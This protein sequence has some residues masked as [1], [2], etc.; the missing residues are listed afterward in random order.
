[1]PF[2]WRR[3]FAKRKLPVFFVRSSS[4]HYALHYHG[5]HLP[6]RLSRVCL[7]HQRDELGLRRLK[8]DIRYSDGDVESVLRTHD[9]VDAHLRKLGVGYLE[10]QHDDVSQAIQHQARDGIHQI[11]T[12]RMSARP[13]QGVVD[14]HC[15]VHTVGNLFVASSS[16][17]PTSGQAN[18]TLTI[19]ALSLRLADHLRARLAPS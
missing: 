6:N 8:I 19:V 3:Y 1:V 10:Y 11:G 14:P 17:F 7:S 15:R 2:I 4:N 16:V 13:D 18:P 12:T 9:I 5:E